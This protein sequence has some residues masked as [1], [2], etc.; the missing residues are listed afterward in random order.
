[1]EKLRRDVKLESFENKAKFPISLKPTVLEIGLIT[2]R[3]NRTI[4]DNLVFHLMG[5]LPYNRFTLKVILHNKVR[6]QYDSRSL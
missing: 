4:D 5:I 1:M 3:K 6:F 2:F